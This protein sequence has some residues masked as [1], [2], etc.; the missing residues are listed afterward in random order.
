MV[1]CITNSNSGGSGPTIVVDQVFDATSQNPQS[2][3]AIAGAGFA[4]GSDLT[5]AITSLTAAI[6]DKVAISVYN[7]KMT[8]VDSSITTLT[9]GLS[10]TDS[11][12]SG[13][14]TS[15]GTNTNSITT[16]NNTIGN[17]PLPSGSTT[18]T[19]AISAL[20]S[21]IGSLS[22]NLGNLNTDVSGLSSDVSSL[23]TAV[24]NLLAKTPVYNHTDYLADAGW[25]A[26]SDADTSAI[27]PYK[28]T[29]TTLDVDLPVSSS[30]NSSRFSGKVAFS[31]KVVLGDVIAPFFDFNVVADQGGNYNNFEATYYS[32]SNT[33]ASLYGEDDG[34]GHQVIIAAVGV[35]YDSYR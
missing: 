18:L 21:S 31:P 25:V 2:G 13:L 7:T 23:N 5:S 29:I 11:T 17:T 30:A 24:A 1:N 35:T 10:A 16:I 22:T 15:V 3:V 6:N 12:V 19:Q 32:K 34:Y 9:T 28:Q 8:S 26:N 27:Y 20:A 14:S 4:S 33:A